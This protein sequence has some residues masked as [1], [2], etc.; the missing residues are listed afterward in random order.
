MTTASGQDHG[1]LPQPGLLE[2]LEV[3]EGPG[4]PETCQ[5]A[6]PFQPARKWIEQQICHL[7]HEGFNIEFSVLE[8]GLLNNLMSMCTTVHLISM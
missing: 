2:V 7:S 5:M 8:L 1:I 3:P 4:A 6:G